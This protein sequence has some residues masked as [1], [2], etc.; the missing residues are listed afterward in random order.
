MPIRVCPATEFDDLKA[1]LGPKRADANVG[2]CL[3]YRLASKENAALRGL[4]RGAKA[5]A[6]RALCSVNRE[7]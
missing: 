4:A 6:A 5:A 1:V 2:W 3:T 7:V